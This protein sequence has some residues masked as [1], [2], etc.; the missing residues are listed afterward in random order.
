MSERANGSPRIVAIDSTYEPGYP[1]SLTAEEY[2]ALIAPDGGRR[3]LAAAAA[4]GFG[5]ASCLHAEGAM[6]DEGTQRGA[7]ERRVLEVLRSLSGEHGGWFSTSEIQDKE[8]PTGT[9]KVPRIPISF[10]NSQM[11][12]FDD[13]RARQLAT[14]MFEAYGLAPASG[15][16]IESDGIEATID[17]LDV[18]RKVGF[19]LRGAQ[20]SV[21]PPF[22]RIN[23]E[24]EGE[25]LDDVEARTCSSRGIELHVADVA[26]YPLMDGDQF[27]PTLAYLAGIVE[28]LNE[29]TDGPDI[30]LT[31]VLAP[32]QQRFP[33]PEDAFESGPCISAVVHEGD[34][35][36]LH[37][38]EGARLDFE[39]SGPGCLEYSTRVRPRSWGRRDWGLLLRPRSTA[40][41]PTMLW[42]DTHSR[43]L[44][45]RVTQGVGE[46]RLDVAS[47]GPFVFLPSTFDAAEPFHLTLEATKT[48]KLHL[49]R[50]V[51]VGLVPR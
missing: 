26:D 44:R 25:W 48:G 21:V 31:A 45:L 49:D 1:S 40:G 28:F 32:A 20:S 7:R 47:D 6:Q 5:L 15:A 29:T 2:R 34:S 30:D 50:Y 17:G 24:S 14:R 18:A 33:L 4:A 27:T 8:M 36:H 16:V 9:A 37:V 11:G 23:A 19:E 39:L 12:V 22:G 41:R 38:T 13:A 51:K 42:I 43:G 3:L 10:G 35:V 46:R